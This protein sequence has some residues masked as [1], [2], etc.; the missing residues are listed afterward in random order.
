MSAGELFEGWRNNGLTSYAG[1]LRARGFDA[2][3]ILEALREANRARCMPPL[4]DNEVRNIAKSA[5]KWK[6]YRTWRGA[7]WPMERAVHVPRGCFDPRPDVC[8]FDPA[9]IV[10]ADMSLGLWRNHRALYAFLAGRFGPWGCHPAIRTIGAELQI[11]YQHVARHIARLEHAG[12]ILTE[13]GDY[14]RSERKFA[15]RSYHFLRHALFAEHFTR[16]GLPVFNEIGGFCH[17]CDEFSTGLKNSSLINQEVTGILSHRGDVVPITQLG[18]ALSR[19]VAVEKEKDPAQSPKRSRDEIPPFAF[20]TAGFFRAC[21]GPDKGQIVHYS[22][23]V[24]YIECAA[25]CGGA[26]I[27]YND[28]VVKQYECSCEVERAV[29]VAA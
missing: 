12:L 19:S 1:S 2:A 8:G 16:Q 17:Q 29:K 7:E 14:R 15:A 3:H 27:I 9:A 28:G 6:P 4:P 25:R 24:E 18:A 11:S 23:I 22:P 13:A 20:E 21:L 26:R 10:Q 5:G